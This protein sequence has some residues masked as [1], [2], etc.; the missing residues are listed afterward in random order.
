MVKLARILAY[1]AAVINRDL[2]LK[3]EYLAA[4][5]KILKAQLKTRPKL[6]E[7][8][9]RTLAD[10]GKKLGRK[11]LAEVASIVSPDTLFRW[12][13]ELIARKFDG[14]KKRQ[15][16]GRPPAEA[17]IEELVLQFARANRSWGYRRIVGAL[18]NVG[19]EISHQTVANILKEHGVEPAPERGKRMKW[20]EFIK[21]HLSVL[22]ATDFFTVEV[23]GLKGLVTYYVLFVIDLATRRV[24]LAGL[25]HSPDE[26]WMKTVALQLTVDGHGFLNGKRLLIR[27]RDTKFTAAFDKILKDAGTKALLLPP[28]SPNL[29]AFAERWVRSVRT[30]CLDKLIPIGESA[31]LHAIEEYLR[32]YDSSTHYLSRRLCG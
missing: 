25:T 5:N 23:L 27:D 14:S 17:E 8:E 28:H 11:L 19:H 31:L 15:A 21:T 30:E 1:V 16:T 29:N 24:H 26:T 32:H 4:E 3:C 6:S 2:L 20:S 18:A 10:L 12:Y 13:R 9:K 7:E 22:A